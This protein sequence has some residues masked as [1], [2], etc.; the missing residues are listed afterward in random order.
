[1]KEKQERKLDIGISLTKAA[2]PAANNTK[3]LRYEGKSKR[4]ML[5]SRQQREGEAAARCNVGD[6][7]KL[8]ASR[9]SMKGRRSCFSLQRK[10]RGQSIYGDKWISWEKGIR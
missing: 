5:L 2:A 7:N 6:A 9:L 10:L 8:H 4:C 1:M 3:E